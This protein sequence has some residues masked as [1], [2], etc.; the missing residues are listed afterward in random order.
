MDAK[1]EILKYK[2]LLE[3]TQFGF[4]DFWTSARRCISASY[5]T[6]S[7]FCFFSFL[8]WNLCLKLTGQ[9]RFEFIQGGSYKT[10]DFLGVWHYS[11]QYATVPPYF[12]NVFGNFWKKV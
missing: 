5:A 8:A 1:N 6:F 2:D 7:F 9:K 12:E 4:Q 10:T 3:I 11:R